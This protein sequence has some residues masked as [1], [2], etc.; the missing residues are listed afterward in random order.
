[1]QTVKRKSAP[2]TLAARDSD[3]GRPAAYWAERERAQAAAIDA[4]MS[5]RRQDGPLDIC[6]GGYEVL[7]R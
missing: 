5:A 2:G 7:E 6:D 1:M 3:M 4:S